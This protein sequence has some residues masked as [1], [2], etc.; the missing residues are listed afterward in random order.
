[1]SDYK[2]FDEDI[3]IHINSV[4]MTLR[5]IGIGPEK[6]FVIYGPNESWSDFVGDKETL[7]VALKSYVYLKVRLLFDPPNNAT[8]IESMNNSIKEFEWR[9]YS[10]VNYAVQ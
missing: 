8:L 7:L 4:L 3:I 1:M 9:L 6:G 5:Q 10:E 2:H